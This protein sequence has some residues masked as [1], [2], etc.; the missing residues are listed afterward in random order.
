MVIVVVVTSKGLANARYEAVALTVI[1]VDRRA[2]E[3]H[4]VVGF[5]A[6]CRADVSPGSQGDAALLRAHTELILVKQS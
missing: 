1:G 6:L 3:V 2:E 5:E 4:L